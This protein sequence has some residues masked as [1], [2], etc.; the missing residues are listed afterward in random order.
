MVPIIDTTQE[1]IT[2]HLD[3]NLPKFSE[4]LSCACVTGLHSFLIESI[5]MSTF[6]DFSDSRGG[7]VV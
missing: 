6:I 3:L 4:V 5:W 2:T 7:R 1:N